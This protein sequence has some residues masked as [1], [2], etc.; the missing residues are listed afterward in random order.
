MVGVDGA[1][2]PEHLV[3]EDGLFAVGACDGGGAGFEVDGDG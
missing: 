2:G 3:G 1:R